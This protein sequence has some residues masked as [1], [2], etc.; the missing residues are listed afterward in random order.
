VFVIWFYVLEKLHILH[1]SS[2]VVHKQLNV[3]SL[4]SVSNSMK[5]I[6]IIIA[7]FIGVKFHNFLLGRG[8]LLRLCFQ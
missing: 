7:L 4:H 1:M 3:S 8:L 2:T 5:M 6:V